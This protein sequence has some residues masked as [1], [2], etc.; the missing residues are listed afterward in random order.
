MWALIIIAVAVFFGVMSTNK[1][2]RMTL[3]HIH[4]TEVRPYVANTLPLSTETYH[5]TI[6]RI[7][8]DIAGIGIC[9]NIANGLLAGIL[10]TLI[11]QLLHW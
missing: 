2:W 8:E 11:L 9:A 5:A 6:L 3:A 10:A 7:R 1:L 4:T